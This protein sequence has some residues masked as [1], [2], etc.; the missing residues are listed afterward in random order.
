VKLSLNFKVLWDSFDEK[1]F[2]SE[3]HVKLRACIH[4]GNAGDII[5]SLPT[6]KE[7]GAGHYII[8]LASDPAFGGLGGR[9]ITFPIARA[10]APLLLS[11]PYIKRVTIVSSN[12]PLEF[13]DQPIEGVDFILDKFRLHEPGKHHLAICH[14]LAFEVHINLYEK[15][16]HVE[17]GKSDHDYIV[18][19][20]TPRYRSLPKEYWPEVLSGLENVVAIGLPQEFHCIAGITADF[21]TCTDFLEM[22]KMI[23]GCRLFI[24]NQNFPYAIAEGLKAPRIV[25]VF[26]EYQN[27]YPIGRSGYIA[28]H[29]TL[30]ARNLIDRLIADSPEEI[31]KHQNSALCQKIAGLEGA[32]RERVAEAEGLRAGLA[33]KEREVGS[34]NEGLRQKE[35]HITNLEGIIV[36]LNEIVSQ[37]E[38][39]IT[40][41]EGIIVS[42]NEIVSQKETHITNLEGMVRERVAEAGGLRA[43]LAEK[44]REVGS[45]NEGLRQKE[46]HITNLEGMVRER[47]AEAEGL[48]AGLAEKEG[49]IVSLNEIVSQ[50]ETHTGNLE[51][52]IR[53]KEGTLN[54][55][56]NSHGWKTLLAYYRARDRVLPVGTRR[57]KFAVS[58]FKLFLIAP[59]ITNK[60]NVI[61]TILFRP[62]DNCPVTPA[63]GL[64]EGGADE[65]RI[66]DS[67]LSADSLPITQSV[68]GNEGQIASLNQAVAE[69]DGQLVS[70]PTSRDHLAAQLKAVHASVSYRAIQ[71]LRGFGPLMAVYSF[72]RSFFRRKTKKNNRI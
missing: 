19:A 66:V 65:T 42:L 40:N 54:H 11:Q 62:K 33:E 9:S 14:A 18:V 12:L 52:E 21:V 31:L 51:T 63:E 55:I 44:E 1:S 7:L 70:M 26:P 47:V 58:I 41:L 3:E 53:E 56:Y 24:G 8:N 15:W 69:R 5:Y 59:Q 43:G 48:R 37:K 29:S 38:G 60:A 32:V 39:H 27:A 36:S 2:P 23:Q 50:K 10:L 30:E 6:A 46:G 72:F 13:L 64:G 25:E 34:L 45:L 35:G 20:L 57:R 4:S 22:A 49:I 16:L 68:A 28:P 71:R 67:A 61:G 17:S